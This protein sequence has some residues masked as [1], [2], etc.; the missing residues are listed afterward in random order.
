MNE[1][2]LIAVE[3]LVREGRSEREIEQAVE[4]LVTEDVQALHDDLDALGPPS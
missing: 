2:Y 3:R 4:E 1:H